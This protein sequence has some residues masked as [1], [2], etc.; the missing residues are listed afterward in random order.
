M[1]RVMESPSEAL[2]RRDLENARLCT[3]STPLG[4]LTAVNP[5]DAKA[6]IP[7][8]SRVFGSVIEVSAVVL[9]NADVSM[10][11]SPAGGITTVV[12]APQLSKPACG[13][14]I[15]PADRLT[16]ARLRQLE[17]APM[18][19]I[20]TEF[21]RVNVVRPLLKKANAPIVRNVGGKIT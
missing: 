2:T 15:K 20:W 3:W 6:C 7:I 17:K 8:D 14:W 12:S 21:G 18:P 19:T 10:I 4:T 1:T 13:S 9:A 16:D 5:E 11:W